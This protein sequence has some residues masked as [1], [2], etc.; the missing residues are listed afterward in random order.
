V[1]DLRLLPP[2]AAERTLAAHALRARFRG[3]GARVLAQA[4]PA[5]AAV[6]RGARIEVWLSAAADPEGAA[7]PDLSGLAVREALRRL[8]LREVPARIVGRGTVVRQDPPPGTPLPLRGPCTL[9]CE[10]RLPAATAAAAPSSE[11]P[12]ALA[13]WGP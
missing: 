1:P 5:G 2:R 7:L 10:P 11:A 8:G 9:W 4:P 6:E 12:A 3:E 13:G